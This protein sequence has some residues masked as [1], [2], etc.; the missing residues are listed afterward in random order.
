MEKRTV[1]KIYHVDN[2]TLIIAIVIGIAFRERMKNRKNFLQR[3]YIQLELL[4]TKLFVAV[5][6]SINRPIYMT[7]LHWKDISNTALFYLMRI[8]KIPRKFYM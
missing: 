8:T 3:A 5:N 1:K 2:Y 7:Y 4:F 6:Y